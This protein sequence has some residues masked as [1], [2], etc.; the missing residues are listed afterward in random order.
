[1]SIAYHSLN[2]H[3]VGSQK[4]QALGTERIGL[5]FLYRAH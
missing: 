4:V 1:M 3:A 5:V 2:M